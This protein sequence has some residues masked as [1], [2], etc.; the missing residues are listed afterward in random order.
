M[1]IRTGKLYVR[2]F[3]K[4]LRVRDVIFWMICLPQFIAAVQYC[5]LTDYSVYYRQYTRIGESLSLT[6]LLEPGYL[7]LNTVFTKL[8]FSF[9]MFYGIYICVTLFLIF[10]YIYRNTN[11][12]HLAALLFGIYPYINYL[13]QLRSAL[14]A[15]IICS[16]LLYLKDSRDNLGIV[17]YTIWVL[18][19]SSLQISNIVFLGMIIVKFVSLKQLKTFT[20][21]C[22]AVVPLLIYYGYE[23]VYEFIDNIKIFQRLKHNL[24]EFRVIT[25]FSLFIIV[26]FLL[27]YLFM[28]YILYNMDQKKVPHIEF[29]GKVAF[30]IVLFSLL[31]CISDNAYRLAALMLPAVYVGLMNMIQCIRNKWKRRCCYLGTIAFASG[32]FFGMWGPMNPEMYYILTNVMWRVKDYF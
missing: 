29:E 26:L 11:H 28:V 5:D 22:F 3:E 25:K 14:G 9:Q 21:W 20:G 4:T 18:V 23:K 12:Y 31:I 13:Q 10:R 15:A 24:P 6:Y 2:G 27:L 16:A 32:I 30:M 8:N 1:R 7:F 17:K 19:A